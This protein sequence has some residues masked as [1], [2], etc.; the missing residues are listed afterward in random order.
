MADADRF[1]WGRPPPGL[2]A[3]AVRLNLTELRALDRARVFLELE[4]Q[5]GQCSRKELSELTG[6]STRRLR[7]WL[8]PACPG[9]AP[10]GRPEYTP[11]RREAARRAYD[12]DDWHPDD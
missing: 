12:A 7:K 3:D 6:V 11:A 4:R 10:R 8:G 9:N 5:G 1:D 2:P